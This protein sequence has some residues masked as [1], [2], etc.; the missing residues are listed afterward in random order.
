MVIFQFAKCKRSPGRVIQELHDRFIQN[1]NSL[2]S[3]L[4][5]L[6]RSGA[7]SSSLIV[8]TAAYRTR[9]RVGVE[10]EGLGFKEKIWKCGI[11]QSMATQQLGK[12]KDYSMVIHGGSVLIYWGILM[13][14]S[15]NS[16]WVFRSL[17]KH[18]NIFQL[19]LISAAKSVDSASKV[20]K[21]VVFNRRSFRG[22][23]V[24]TNPGDR[25]CD[26]CCAAEAVAACGQGGCGRGGLQFCGDMIW[27]NYNELTTSEPWKS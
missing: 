27:V 4:R 8:E 9:R 5:G 15:S 21:Q 24:A 10:D 14:K 16:W 22:K 7:S 12:L 6:E 11:C 1:S 13:I 26:P 2:E 25:R 3:S 20:T 18:P 17:R 23:K 19:W